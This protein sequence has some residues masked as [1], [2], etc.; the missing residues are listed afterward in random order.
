[1]LYFKQ[2]LC[3]LQALLCIVSSFSVYDSNFKLSVDRAAM[4]LTSVA[5]FSFDSITAEELKIKTG[6]AALQRLPFC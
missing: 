5:D 6:A 2:I 4:E 1:M 3:I